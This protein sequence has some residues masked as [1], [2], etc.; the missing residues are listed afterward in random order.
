MGCQP[1]RTYTVGASNINSLGKTT[2]E[3][4]SSRGPTD[5]GGDVQDPNPIGD[6][7]IC[8]FPGCSK[9]CATLRGI[10]LHEQKMHKDFYDARVLRGNT[11]NEVGHTKTLKKRWTE[12]EKSLLARREVQFTKQGVRLMNVALEE[13]YQVNQPGI[14]G[15]TLEAIKGQRRTAGHKALVAQYLNEANDEVNDSES[16]SESEEDEA[17]EVEE[18]GAASGSEEDADD[19]SQ[20]IDHNEQIIDFIESLSAT[21]TDKF[22]SNILNNMYKPKELEP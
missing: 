22:A 19:H 13:W 20:N 16:E 11:V 17:F 3:P 1:T 8:E 18:L 21:T 7:K 9:T 4:S 10:R 5:D 12:E 14:D 2:G 15:R 6:Q